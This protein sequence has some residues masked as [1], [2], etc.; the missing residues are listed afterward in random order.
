MTRSIT[1]KR[2]T[3]RGS[4]S[5]CRIPQQNGGVLYRLYRRDMKGKLHVIRLTYLVEPDRHL[6]ARQLQLNRHVLRGFVDDID[7]KIMGVTQ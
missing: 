6:V 7:L 5:F 3:G 4:F 2:P 1:H